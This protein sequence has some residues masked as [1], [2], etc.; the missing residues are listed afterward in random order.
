MTIK[1][2]YT[3]KLAAG[4]EIHGIDDIHEMPNRARLEYDPDGDTV[5]IDVGSSGIMTKHG[6]DVR[7]RGTITTFAARNLLELLQAWSSGSYE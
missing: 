4:P 7:V 1:T 5:Y 2:G 6:A 3:I